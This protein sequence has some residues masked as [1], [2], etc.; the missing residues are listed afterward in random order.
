MPSDILHYNAL[1]E[2]ARAELENAHRAAL[3]AEAGD[4]RRGLQMSLDAMREAA[5]MQVDTP[6]DGSELAAGPELLANMRGMV[7]K[8]LAELEDGSLADMVSRIEDAR[9]EL[10][11]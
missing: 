8:A 1:I 9:K 11:A 4:L 7:E 3:S 2:T 6:G 5:A 10:G